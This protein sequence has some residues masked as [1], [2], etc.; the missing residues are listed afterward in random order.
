VRD[1]LLFVFNHLDQFLLAPRAFK[2]APIVVWFVR[3]NGDEPHLRITKFATRTADYS[4]MR[5]D[6]S[7]R[8]GALF[9][10]LLQAEA[11]Y[12]LS[13]TGAQRFVVIFICR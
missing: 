3:L 11:R 9:D 4:W 12:G 10:L 7:L 6:L 1:P 8:H 5:N 13:A 2:G